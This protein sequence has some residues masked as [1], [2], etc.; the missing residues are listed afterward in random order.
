MQNNFKNKK[1]YI[2]AILLIVIALA[3][4]AVV[5]QERLK[6]ESGYRDVQI[7]VNMDDVSS[8]ANSQNISVAEMADILKQ[9]DVSVILFKERSIADLVRMG[10]MDIQVGRNILNTPYSQEISADLQP[11]DTEV[12]VAIL[13]KAWQ[14]Q[15]W[16][17]IEQKVEACQYYPANVSI[18]AIPGMIA[19]SAQELSTMTNEIGEIGLGWENADIE[20]MAELGFGNKPQIRDWENATDQSLRFVTD[21]IKNM[22]SLYAIL[23]NDKEIIGYRDN[24]SVRT[25]ADLLRNESG[26]SI[27][28]IASIEFNDQAGLNTLG[29]LLNKNVVRL[30]TISNSEMSKFETAGGMEEAMDRWMLAARERNM[31]AL[32]VRFFDIDSPAVSFDKNM[33]YLSV[34]QESLLASDFT[35]GNT[36]YEKPQAVG[37]NQLAVLIVG[38]GVAAGFMLLLML[39][40]FRK[41][42]VL[43]FLAALVCWGGVYLLN[44]ILARKLMAL[45]SVII[46]PIIAS[47]VML[48]SQSSN[49]AQSIGKVVIMSLISFIGAVFMVGLISDTSFMLKLDSFVGVKI[50][51]IIPIMVVPF[52]LYIWN[53]PDP[54]KAAQEILQRAVTYKW[55]ILAAVLAVCG[56]IYIS[57]TSNTTAELSTAE[58][59][60]RTALNDWLGVRPRSKEFLIGYPFLLLLFYLGAG[61]Q[62]WVLTL[63]AVIGQVSLVNTYAHIHTPLLISL[64]RSFNGLALGLVIGIVLVLAVKFFLIWWRRYRHE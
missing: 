47:L 3:A 52:V 54:L 36:V 14:E 45:V 1:L 23:F 40:R 9:K 56:Y 12:Y 8:L 10:K 20:Q 33:E 57:R 60:M 25:V 5:W 64:Q 30:H 24:E 61:K 62:N 31:R 32:L 58:S 26:E 35:L 27:A 48:K 17:N 50:A 63:P 51:H 19:S 28:P 49:L 7:V 6:S 37:T 55:A 22:P 21:E 44:P 46:F 53:T 4:S 11:K 38:V 2:F 43:G 13:D 34:L 39:L 29:I 41:L 18:I 16:N 15:A 42:A 59:T